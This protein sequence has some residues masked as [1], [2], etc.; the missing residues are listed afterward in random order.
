VPGDLENDIEELTNIP[1][2][3]VVVM[4]QDGY[5]WR[6]NDFEY[7]FSVTF[8]LNCFRRSIER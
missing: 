2:C 4:T 8:L 7:P 1:M 6:M 3:Q 5:S